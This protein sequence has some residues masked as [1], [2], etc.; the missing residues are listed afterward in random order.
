MPQ[1]RQQPKKLQY[2][3]EIDAYK[4]SVQ[5]AM[6]IYELSKSFP[7]EEKYFLFFWCTPEK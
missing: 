3:W 1:E 4:L 6:E 7:D 2:H 5:A